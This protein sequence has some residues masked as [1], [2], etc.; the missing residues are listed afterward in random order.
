MEGL[1]DISL[2]LT[3]EDA[4]RAYRGGPSDLQAA[5]PAGQAPAGP[6][7]RLGPGRGYAP[8]LSGTGRTGNGARTSLSCE[9]HRYWHGVEWD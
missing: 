6:G 9:F 7:G 8:V 2:T 1:D 3:Q 4:I 5:Y